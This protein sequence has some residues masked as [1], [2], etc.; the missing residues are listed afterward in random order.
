MQARGI[1]EADPSLDIEGWDAAAKAAALANVLLGARLTPRT[2]ERQGITPDTGR[3]ALEARAAG[4]RV[5]LVARVDRVG[6]TIKAS[7]A[8]EALPEDDLLAGLEGQQNAIIFR[9]DLL[10]EIAVVQRGGSLTHTA[11]ALVS[12]LVTLARE[13]MLRPGAPARRKK[14]RATR[15]SRS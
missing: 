14:A 8:P 13:N 15:R 6:R 2:V 7:V 9:T 10:D 12:D 4:R 3:Q 1:A 11:Y 5:K